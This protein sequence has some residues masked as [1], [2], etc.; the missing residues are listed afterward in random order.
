ML[1]RRNNSSARKK[2]RATFAF[3]HL[4]QVTKHLIYPVQVSPPLPKRSGFGIARDPWRRHWGF[5]WWM[6]DEQ[7]MCLFLF[8]YYYLIS[9]HFES[10]NLLQGSPFSR[11][12]NSGAC[13][14]Y[15]SKLIRWLN[16]NILLISIYY[17]KRI[18]EIFNNLQAEGIIIMIFSSKNIEIALNYGQKNIMS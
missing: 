8:Y 4:L 2:E 11:T 6:V 13:Y 14:G 17:Y 16:K 1:I 3:S 12:L 15:I 7:I 5:V 10:I 18:K 9:R